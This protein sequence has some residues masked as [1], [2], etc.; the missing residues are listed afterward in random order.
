LYQKASPKTQELVK[1]L[2]KRALDDYNDL[3]NN[4]YTNANK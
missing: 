4:L 1:P 2:M 3:K